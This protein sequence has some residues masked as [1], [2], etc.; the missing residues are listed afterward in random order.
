M[1]NDIKKKTIYK[2]NGGRGAILCNFCSA[3]I[4]QG[5]S[6]PKNIME[7]FKT[8]ADNGPQYCCEQCK[9]NDQYNDWN[10]LKWNGEGEY[11]EYYKPIRFVLTYSSKTYFGYLEP[12]FEI[13]G[14]EYF[15]VKDSDELFPPERIKC[16]RYEDIGTDI[17][18]D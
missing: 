12:P 2:F 14:K 15:A 11:P 17:V 6:I 8:G 13:D 5:S 4:Y 7:G 10:I 9:D 18:K 16:W 3:I 1:V